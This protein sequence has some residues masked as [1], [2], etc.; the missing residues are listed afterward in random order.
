MV[1]SAAISPHALNFL[2]IFGFIYSLE[3]NPS[4][5]IKTETYI[6]AGKLN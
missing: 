6:E 5:T 4:G 2:N 3:L 1:D